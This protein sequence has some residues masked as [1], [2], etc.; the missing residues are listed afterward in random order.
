MI[1]FDKYIKYKLKY[2]ALKKQYGGNIE[3]LYHGH[4]FI[5]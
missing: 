2:L 5:K 1:Y 4:H 3:Y